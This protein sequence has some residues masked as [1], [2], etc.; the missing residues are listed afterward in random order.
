M[1]RKPSPWEIGV[2]LGLGSGDIARPCR[3]WE[4]YL[5][6]YRIKIH[7]IRRQAVEAG[8]YSAEDGGFGSGDEANYV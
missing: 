5:E 3:E 7:E 8:L 6:P 2:V 4:P 1:P